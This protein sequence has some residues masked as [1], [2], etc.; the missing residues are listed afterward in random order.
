MERRLAL[1]GGVAALGMSA[2][3]GGNGPFSDTELAILQTFNI[4]AAVLPADPS[5]AVADDPAA[6]AL[7]KAFYFEP[8]FSGALGPDND[9]VT[10]GSVGAAGQ[11]G[12]LSCQSCHDLL[13][14]TASG[15][16]D[17]S[18][19]AN[20]SLGA[21]YTL[22]NAPTIIN[23]AFS[24]TW[25]FWDGRKDSLWGQ[26]LAPTENPVEA[27]G[28]RLRVAHLIQSKYA[29]AY[30]A[31]FPAAPSNDPTSN[32]PVLADLGDP[33]RFPS[34]GKP[35]D[36][37]FD[38]LAPPDQDLVNRVFANYGKALEAYERRLTSRAF[39]KAPFDQFL[40]SLAGDSTYANAS[41]EPAA[42]RGA[43]LFIGKA[44]CR[45]CHRGPL[46]TDFQFHDIGVPQEG[47]HVPASDDGRYTGAAALAADPFNRAGRYS[48]DQTPAP[49]EQVALAGAPA[50][51]DVGRFKTPSLRNVGKTAPYMHDGYY[52]TLWDV[53]N[54]YNFA[55]ATGDYDGEL[56][57]ALSPLLLTDAELGDLV[58]FLGSLSDGAVIDS[59]SIA[60]P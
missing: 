38:D 3:C 44:G 57:V 48:D 13:S 26:A 5:N 4:N 20:A 34:D 37:A 7:G 27:N 40:Q 8:G 32:P 31:V 21:A 10:N 53:V 60:P 36:P 35:G 54:H 6:A 47:A 29:D 42:I 58:E 11:V 49:D 50:T 52:Q 16:D 28:S 56:D 17:R 14:P 33:A 55:G 46:L 45:E 19:P 51:E 1:W 22:R 18:A 39:T 30:T 25:Q 41:L 43:K 59:T 2:G 9:G 12:R 23:A 24:A 15:S